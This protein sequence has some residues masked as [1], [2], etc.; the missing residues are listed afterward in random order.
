MAVIFEFLGVDS[1]FTSPEFDQ[2]LY[3]AEEKRRKTRLGYAL[4]KAAER[5]RESRVRPYL[6]RRLMAPINALNALTAR[7]IPAPTLDPSLRSRIADCLRP[8]VDRLRSFTGKP[9]ETWLR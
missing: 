4:L 1:S 5:V 2:T 8:D 3:S 7:P 9:L 6:S